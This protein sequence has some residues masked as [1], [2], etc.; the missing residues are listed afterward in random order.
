[1]G[2]KRVSKAGKFRAFMRCV[3][4]VHTSVLKMRLFFAV[5]CAFSSPV[6][7]ETATPNPF[8][9][10]DL[11]HQLTYPLP[12]PFNTTGYYRIPSLVTS[13]NG[14]LLAFIMGRFHRRDATP[15]IVYLRRS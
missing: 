13:T 10:T 8:N 2:L 3:S 5:C 11:F 6:R 9:T 1:M 7:S 14:T 12:Y 15:N 4:H